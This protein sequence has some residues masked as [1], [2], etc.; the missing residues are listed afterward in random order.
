MPRRVVGLVAYA[1]A[2]ASVICCYCPLIDLAYGIAR[3]W[4]SDPHVLGGKMWR[5]FVLEMTRPESLAFLVGCTGLA[6]L[7]VGFAYLLVYRD[8]R[9]GRV[10]LPAA[11]GRLAALG[12]VGVALDDMALGLIFASR[13]LG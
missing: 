1:L 7:T 8:R 3:L 6:S 11:A 9:Q 4:L 2:Y 12:L 13:L 5:P 10:S